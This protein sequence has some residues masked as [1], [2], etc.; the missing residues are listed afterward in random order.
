MLSTLASSAAN[1]TIAVDSALEGKFSV[2]GDNP[3]TIPANSI[4]ELSIM[5]TQAYQTKMYIARYSE[6]FT[7][8]S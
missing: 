4:V 2:V 6:P 3:I 8:P 7:R 5:F 1:V